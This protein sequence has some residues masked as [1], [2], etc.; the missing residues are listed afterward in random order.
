MS[1]LNGKS[2]TITGAAS[3]IGRAAAISAARDGALLTLSDIDEGGCE[4]TYR[5][6]LDLGAEAIFLRTD[7]SRTDDIG[8]M[9]DMAVRKFGRLDGAFNNAGVNM[10]NMP[11]IELP[12]EVF[13]RVHRIN[14]TSVFL[15]MK[16]QA[17]AMLKT[18]GG[19]IVNTSSTSAISTVPNMS[20]YAS[21]KASI[22][23][24]TRTAALELARSGVR[25]NAILPGVTRTKM[26]EEGLSRAP[27]MEMQVVAKLPMG[28]MGEPHEVAALALW[29]LSDEASIMT[30]ACIPADGGL[31]IL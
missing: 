11:L 5:S 22:L 8:H 7:V 18:G 30:G 13:E 10:A 23:A 4:E 29:L 14:S 16:F 17:Q 21:A 26:C 12:E 24:L 3:G 28:R 31:S 27:D 6:V 25:V 20:E 2:I 19:S 15:C 1:R 9:V